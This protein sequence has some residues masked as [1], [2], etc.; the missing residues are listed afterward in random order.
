MRGAIRDAIVQV[1]GL[2]SLMIDTRVLQFGFNR[3]FNC[4]IRP[5]AKPISH[6][7]RLE[8]LS[9]GES[10]NSTMP[11]SQF[12]LDVFGMESGR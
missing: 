2:A 5:S 3:R 1:Y 9:C 8:A 6:S 4:R 10:T 7:L 12:R 11:L